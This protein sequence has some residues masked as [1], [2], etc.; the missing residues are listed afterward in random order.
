MTRR[1]FIDLR[2]VLTQQK[3]DGKKI[4]TEISKLID[5]K[6]ILERINY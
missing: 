4:V 3:S 5:N 1:P 2:M 6:D